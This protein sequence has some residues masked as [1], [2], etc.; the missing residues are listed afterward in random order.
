MSVTKVTNETR[1]KMDAVVEDFKRKLANIRTGRATVG[2]LD[3]VM[4]DYY[5][6]PT[7][8]NQMA[9]VAV[10]EPQLLTVQPWDISQVNAV[11]KAII[12]ANLGMNPSNDGKIIRLPV[13]PLNEERR[14]QL[15]K[16]V[17]EV[18]E[19]HR[20]A[21]RNVRHSANDVLKKMLKDKE[22]SEDDERSGLD[23]VQKMTNTFVGK[24]DELA[25]HKE[26]DIMS[27]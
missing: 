27:V 6:T 13:P 18:A 22:V 10:P 1:P 25:K 14:K 17:H 5:G 9:S 19:E 11:E 4:V 16:Q 12:A 24:I 26:Q 2:L 7:P 3:T 23:E 21:I 8:L 20:I 15:A